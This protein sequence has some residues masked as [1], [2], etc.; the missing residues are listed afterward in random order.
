[1][2]TSWKRLSVLLS[3]LAVLL[4]LALMPGAVNSASAATASCVSNFGTRVPVVMV[5]GLGSSAETWGGKDDTDSMAH[6]VSQI[7]DAYPDTF[8][9]S[10][11]HYRWVTDKDIGPAL[12]ARIDCL[13]QHSLA[14]HGTGKVIVVGHSM[15]GLAARFAAAQTVNGHK[16]ADEI[17]LVITLGTPNLG[18]GLAN[19]GSGFMYSLC[20]NAGSA[21]SL[22]CDHQVGQTL[23]ALHGLRDNS[24]ELNQLPWLPDSVPTLAIAGD[25]TLHF[26][27]FGGTLTKNFDG[28]LVVSKK[29]A[30]QDIRS[31]DDSGGSATESCDG[32]QPAFVLPSCW[33]VGL[34]KNKS[35]EVK[36]EQAIK[37]YIEATKPVSMTFDGLTIKVPQGWKQGNLLS[38]YVHDGTLGIRTGSTCLNG[39]NIGTSCPGFELHGPDGLTDDW[40]TYQDYDGTGIF[41]RS[42]DAFI[43][44]ADPKMVSYKVN[45]YRT[46][47]TAMVGG[48]KAIY[49]E[50]NVLCG[51]QDTSGKTK[52]FIERTWWL[53][54]SHYLIVDDWQTEGLYD[55]LKNATWSTVPPFKNYAGQWHAAQI[56]MDIKDSGEGTLDW[57]SAGGPSHEAT[58]KLH[59]TPKGAYATIIKGDSGDS[60]AYG[61]LSYTAGQEVPIHIGVSPS[62]VPMGAVTFGDV[63]TNSVLLCGAKDN[64]GCGGM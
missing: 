29:S 27:L 22:L 25:V 52:S 15:G 42:D 49:T 30:L 45:G 13:A 26:K 17:G 11:A 21:A 43:C 44:A 24:S 47:G 1:M 16:V 5:H 23:S 31:V 53:P 60:E 37:R 7:P 39:G 38:D 3:A 2:G 14:N 48:K 61:P 19:L 36:T 50:W 40:F 57:K 51:A 10:T 4:G 41:F 12:A 55:T 34:P 56:G 33:H 64:L 46:K 35:V 59:R 54:D 28:D 32:D 9:Y 6:A 18:S 63:Q 8:D 62:N 58:F 20:Q